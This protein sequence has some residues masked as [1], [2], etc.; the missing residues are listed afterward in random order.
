MSILRA[1]TRPPVE[2]R[3]DTLLDTI[4]Q[5]RR[6][7]SWTGR[8]VTF[9][10]ALQHWAVAAS[11]NF[12]AYLIAALPVH[13]YRGQG[14]DRTRL[15][16]PSQVARPDPQISGVGWRRQVLLS[17]L[18]RGNAWG[19]VLD[20]DSETGRPSVIRI[21]HPDEVQVSRRGKLGNLVVKWNGNE[22]APSERWHLTGYEVPGS[23]IGLSPISYLAQTI[24]L[25][26]SAVEFGA[27][28]FGDGAHPSAKLTFAGNLTPEQAATAKTRFTDSIEGREPFVI[29]DGWT[30]EALSVPADESQFL[31]TIN[32][33]AAQIAT[34]FGLRPEDIGVKSGDSM[35]YA[36]V[37]MRNIGR[38]VYPV[39]QW[40]VRLEERLGEMVPRGQFVRSNVDSLLRVDLKS[41]YTAHALGLRSGFMSQNEV[42]ALE[43]MPPIDDGDRYVWPP[44]ATKSES[45]SKSL[46]ITAEGNEDLELD[47][48]AGSIEGTEPEGE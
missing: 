39:S 8:A 18:L 38:L 30:Y 25:G 23:P 20:Y 47:D 4:N 26:L 2:T 6:L 5:R 37:E 41:R 43:D 14:P 34:M 17:V 29:G 31:E 13:V 3:S 48:E 28:W 15:D 22:L 12:I 1:I 46:S 11:T 32:A 36:N 7:A 45:V 40:L 10:S 16:T 44:N 27:R 35:T 33:N 9:D 21:V 42:R 24:G 19:I